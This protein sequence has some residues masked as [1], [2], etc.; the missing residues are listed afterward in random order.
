MLQ[1]FGGETLLEQTTWEK[2]VCENRMRMEL[3]QG[4]WQMNDTDQWNE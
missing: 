1:N 4:L 3:I 2:T